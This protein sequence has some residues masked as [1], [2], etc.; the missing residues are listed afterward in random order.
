MK[1]SLIDLVNKKVKDQLDNTYYSKVP[2]G[3]CFS[4]GVDHVGLSNLFFEMR[5]YTSIFPMLGTT[6]NNAESIL[7]LVN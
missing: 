2:L 7:K 3:Q 5:V 6:P 1:A 4:T